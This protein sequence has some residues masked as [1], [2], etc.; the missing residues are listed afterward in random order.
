MEEG[1]QGQLR[2]LGQV[3]VGET[4]K[5]P[6]WAAVLEVAMVTKAPA[7]AAV[8]SPHYAKPLMPCQAEMG[9]QQKILSGESRVI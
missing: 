9:G 6:M 3:V 5:R 1:G 8:L 2:A 7:E 4:A